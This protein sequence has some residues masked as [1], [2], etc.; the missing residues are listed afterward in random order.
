MHHPFAELRDQ[1][2][3]V[4]KLYV[5]RDINT[6]LPASEP[7]DAVWLSRPACH[8]DLSNIPGIIAYIAGYAIGTI[9][10]L[11]IEGSAQGGECHV[12]IIVRKIL[13]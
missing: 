10:G 6:W 7:G 3:D 11:D 1:F 4:R 13:N 9:L 5:N 12:R 8:H 2:K